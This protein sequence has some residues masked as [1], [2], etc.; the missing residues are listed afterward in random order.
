[1]IRLDLLGDEAMAA[2]LD[3]LVDGLPK[4]VRQELVTRA[5]GMPLFAVETVRALI[6]R[7]LVVARGGSY[8]VADPDGFDVATI[9]PP[10]SLQALVAARIDALT[11][12]ERRV[13]TDASV[14]GASFGVDAM[15]ALAGDVSDLD[16][17]LK[18]L[19]RKEILALQTDRLSSEYGQLRFVQSVVRQVALS[20]Q[21]RRDRKARHLAVATYLG[22]I[23][24]GELAVVR[25]QHLVDAV[26]ASAADDPD[27]AELSRQARDLLV[28][29]AVRARSLGS[30]AEAARLYDLAL[31]RTS[32]AADR[33]RLC[34]EA[35]KANYDAGAFGRTID[36]G[37]EAIGLW[38]GLGDP[39]G[40][41]E[42]AVAWGSAMVD[43]SQSAAAIE[44]L[45]EHLKAVEQL[46]GGERARLGLL[47]NLGRALHFR[48]DY[49]RAN[50][51]AQRQMRLAESIGD[52][53]QL[54]MAFRRMSAIAQGS[55]MP[56]S[57]I[58]MLRG[59]VDLCRRH[60]VTAELAIGLSNLTTLLGLRDL[61]GAVDAGREG[62][63][64]ARRTGAVIEMT[65]STLNLV[66][67]LTNRGDWE[68]RDALLADET[69]APHLDIAMLLLAI[70]VWRSQA[71]GVP[72]TLDHP[73]L[74]P[75]WETDDENLVGWR[76][77]AQA[78]LAEQAGDL[79]EASRLL[80][81]AVDHI[82]QV[83]GIE[84][85]FI[86]VWPR[87]VRAA[88]RAGRP[89]VAKEL[90]RRVSE[91]PIGI[92]TP[93]HHAY[94]AELQGRIGFA[95]GDDDDAAEAR[96]REGIRL[97]DAFGA[98]PDAARARQLLGLQLRTQARDAEADE[99][100][101]AARAEFLRLGARTWLAEL[102]AEVPATAR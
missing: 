22:G 35:A 27:V 26:E 65:Y 68:E 2:M 79:Q 52:Y 33:A 85:D 20:T 95:R 67:A 93:A 89:E 94:L 13:V 86:H 21:S 12:D 96:L 49:V 24:Q 64:V 15:R 30:P 84:D 46:P 7:D 28:E 4:P 8:V 53:E 25:A 70:E 100:L 74:S 9:G 1:M 87:A 90:V 31:T 98:R 76:F 97:L 37:V 43:Q 23:D 3:A 82:S 36:L 48:G 102:D 66:L 91:A 17:V 40:E 41:A 92:Q 34:T 58:V 32:G 73:T 39:I 63:A 19:Q 6:D 60:G 62:L 81:E 57:A 38:H 45:E 10:A 54:A 14:L 44:P 99:L 47:N 69:I 77:A 83:S 50:D 61:D 78:A 51:Y 80:V 88:V 5:E 29:A 101:A 55:E 42:A 59:G 56:E 18:S 16:A 11:P 71:T 75:D 72:A